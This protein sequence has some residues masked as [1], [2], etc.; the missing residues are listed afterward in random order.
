L[1]VLR[2]L[3]VLLLAS[4]MLAAQAPPKPTG[5]VAGH[6]YLGDSRLPA[7]MASVTLLP[8]PAADSPAAKESPAPSAAPIQPSPDGTITFTFKPSAGPTPA[9]VVTVETLLD[10]SFSI[11][12]VF[13]G[14]YYLIVEKR[15]YLSSVPFADDFFASRI[16]KEQ[17][18]TLA[19]LT[20]LA[21]A[22]NRTTTIDTTLAKG[23][24]IAGTVRFDDGEPDSNTLVTLM[25][26]DKTGKWVKLSS[27]LA[28]DDQGHFRIPGLPA[29]E[30]LLIANLYVDGGNISENGGGS[31]IRQGYDL[32]IYYGEG[33]RQ[34]DAKTIKVTEGEQ[35]DGNNI[36][37]PLAKLHVVTGT[38]VSMETGATINSARVEL[39]YA[40]D[41]SVV[42]E[43]DTS[44][45]GDEFR[46]L[47]VPEGTYTIEVKQAA[48]A[49][50]GAF[51][52]TNKSVRTY[53]DASQSIIVKGETSGVTI[54]VKPLPVSAAAATA[55]T[56]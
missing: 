10:G 52:G 27:S 11:P 53:A 9:S 38:V 14:Q 6:V 54:Q 40:D 33:F 24:T 1:K 47:F 3:V 39:H 35:S 7:R 26:K 18:E 16:S 25:R 50:P 32:D 46:F 22:A 56:Q 28:A 29:G 12:N 2:L 5:V 20:P 21:V 37:I 51:P 48:D 13:P 43:T 42:A 49:I 31:M 30:Y 4:H 41:D 15:G 19:S 36:E 45:E 17:V 44:W 55:G 23:A 8:V 34:K